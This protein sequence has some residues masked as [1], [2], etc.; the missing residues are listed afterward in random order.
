M[1][2]LKPEEKA[3]YDQVAA[4]LSDT[5]R[6]FTEREA[7]QPVLQQGLDYPIFYDYA[8]RFIEVDPDGGLREPHWRLKEHMLVNDRLLNDLRSGAWDGRDLDQRLEELDKENH[9]HTI[10]YAHDKRLRQNHLGNW[11]AVKEA[12]VSIPPAVQQ[13]LTTLKPALF[14]RWNAEVSHPWT[15]Q[16]VL[17]T[18]TELGWQHAKNNRAFEYIRTWL[19]QQPEVARVGQDYWTLTHTLPQGVRRVRLAVLPQRDA[20]AEL[21]GAA[22]GTQEEMN[23]VSQVIKAKVSRRPIEGNILVEGDIAR[24]RASWQTCLRTIQ[25]HE[26]FIPIPV[27][28][29]SVYPP[30]APDEGTSFVIKGRW[31][32]DATEFWLWIDRQQHRIYGPGLLQLFDDQVLEPGDVLSINWEPEIIVLRRIDCNEKVQEEEGRLVDLEEIKK[33]RGGIGESYRQ[34]LQTI[35]EEHQR[36]LTL[37]EIVALLRQ[38]QQHHVHSGTIRA[39]LYSG[40]FIQKGQHWFAAPSHEQ[41]K[42]QLGRALLESLVPPE[43][44]ATQPIP[45]TAY[46]KTRAQTIRNRLRD[47]VSMVKEEH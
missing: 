34:S 42:R 43:H 33:L 20:Q 23:N 40:G 29:R 36:G 31:Y 11:E 38:R 47:I 26:G 45:Y 1:S 14:A 30:L 19:L 28:A 5:R 9:R 17:Q 24:M 4:R 10:F 18:L 25:L 35:C 15:C 32:D 27:K 7:M 6:T 22:P 39:L 13:E 37:T 44:I 46:V 3:L 41:G 12:S 2:I 8:D 21:A 16:Q